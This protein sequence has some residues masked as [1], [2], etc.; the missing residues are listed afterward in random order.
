[1]NTSKITI[2]N[3][4]EERDVTWNNDKTYLIPGATSYFLEI[5]LQNSAKEILTCEIQVSKDIFDFLLPSPPKDT[6]IHDYLR[7]KV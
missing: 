2:T 6:D 5:Q 3:Y 1:M 7:M 4:R